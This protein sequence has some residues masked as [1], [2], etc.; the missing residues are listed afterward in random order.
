MF[1]MS[2]DF[3]R[4]RNIVLKH[5]R[6]SMPAASFHRDGKPP[7]SSRITVLRGGLPGLI[8]DRDCLV[9]INV[10]SHSPLFGVEFKPLLY[11]T[12]SGT[13]SRGPSL[14]NFAAGV[15]IPRYPLKARPAASAIGRFQRIW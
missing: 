7:N 2:S 12:R 10:L 13:A 15:E 4:D 9:P 14:L 3:S 5:S 6:D 11:F 8:D 1:S